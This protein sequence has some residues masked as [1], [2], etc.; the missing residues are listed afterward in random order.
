MGDLSSFS[1][2]AHEGTVTE[3][4]CADN[5][6]PASAQLGAHQLREL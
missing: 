5:V 1:Q 6:P 2:D 3:R 4:G